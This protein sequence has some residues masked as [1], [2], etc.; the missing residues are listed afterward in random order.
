MNRNEMLQSATSQEWDVIVVGGGASGLGAAVDAQSRGYRTLLLE[1]HDFAKATSSRSTKLVHGGVRYLQQGNIS[2]VNEALYERGLLCQ[3]ASH[4]VHD[5]AFVVPR[6]KWW[7]GPF[8]GIGLKLYDLLAG[9]LNL[10]PS[11]KLSREEAIARIPNIEQEHLLGGTMYFDGQFDDARLAL[12]LAQTA[13]DNGAALVNYMGVKGFIKDNDLITGVKA[14]DELSGD[15]HEFRGKVVINA[16]G[17]FSDAIR[18][19]DDPDTEMLISQSQGVHLVLDASFQPSKTAIMVPHTDDGRVLFVIPWHER[20]LV[21]T[22]DTPMPKPELEPRPLA[23]EIKFILRN[24][25]RY[26]EKDPTEADVLAVFAGQ[27]PLVHEG[28]TGGKTKSI[29]REHKVEISHG[30]LVS[31]M[32]GKWTTFRRMAEDTVDA[33]APVGGLPTVECRTKTLKLHG[34]MSREDPALPKEGH[35]QMYGSE[36]TA[37]QEF[38][39]QNEDRRKPLHQ[40]LPYLRGQISWAARHEM[41]ICL[42]DVL[43]RRTRSLLL[44][45]KAAI[46]AAPDAARLMAAELGHDEAWVEAQ[47]ASFKEMAA[48]YCLTT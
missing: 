20:V 32:G 30:G 44:N 36:A 9:K 17:I 37:V 28:G 11:R 15:T 47:V 38:I 13:A 22:T 27:R 16:T 48:G 10:A 18:K 23:D 40:G 29:S 45:A 2:L 14:Q 4:L 33:A 6:Y 24:A 25:N 12:T 26:L 39:D 42:E 21:G 43:A 35:F 1:Q 19:M 46:E 5:L 3:N 8:Y 31:I 41:A 7:E 34:W